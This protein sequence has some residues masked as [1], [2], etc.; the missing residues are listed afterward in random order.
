MMK[1][2][3]ADNR[4]LAELTKAVRSI[5]KEGGDFLR[6]ERKNL[7]NSTCKCN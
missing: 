2:N 5:A 6:T 7:L 3:P 4:E 1:Y